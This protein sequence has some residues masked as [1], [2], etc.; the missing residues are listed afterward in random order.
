MRK[1]GSCFRFVEDYKDAKAKGYAMRSDN[2]F[3][4]T[5]K[6]RKGVKAQCASIRQKGEKHANDKG[7][8]YHQYRWTWNMSIT[9]N[10]KWKRYLKN[11]FNK[12]ICVPIGSLRKPIPLKWEDSYDELTGEI[13]KKEVIPSCPHCGELPYSYQQC[14]FCG[15][16]F[17]QDEKTT[18]MLKPPETEYIDCFLCDGKNTVE[19]TRSKINGHF[20][21]KCTA[22]G[23]KY[24]G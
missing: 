14:V 12:F 3:I 21:G 19:G 1:C 11:C 17:M 2:P 18:E 4:R 13:I 5:Q 24:I 8:K 6:P 9:W 23:A 10:F 20:H 15:Q 7:C 22:C 16:R